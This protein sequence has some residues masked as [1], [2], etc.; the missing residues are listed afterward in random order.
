MQEEDFFLEQK[1]RE[2]DR[3]RIEPFDTKQCAWKVKVS[4]LL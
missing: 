3:E 1:W 4:G 2:A